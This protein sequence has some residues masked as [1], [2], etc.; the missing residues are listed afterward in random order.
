MVNRTETYLVQCPR[1]LCKERYRYRLSEVVELH[2][3]YFA[4]TQNLL[5]SEL[6][7]TLNR[8]INNFV[9]LETIIETS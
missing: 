7:Q 9:A 3:N 6:S 1:R 5:K 4:V 2:S 8:F